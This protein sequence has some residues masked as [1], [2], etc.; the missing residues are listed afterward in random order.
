MTEASEPKPHITTVEA[1]LDALRRCLQAMQQVTVAVSGGV[2][3]MTLATVAHQTL[4][5]KAHMVHAVSAAV[6]AAD[7]ARVAEYA[8]TQQWHFTTVQTGEIDTPNY[9]QNPVNR[10][11]FCKSCLYSTLEQLDVGQVVSGTNTDDLGDYRPGLIAAKEHRIRHPYVEANISKAE[12]RAIAKFLGLSEL[13]ELPASPCLASRVETGTVIQPAQ[14][15]LINRVETWLRAQI[16]GENIRCRLSASHIELQLDA[17]LLS[18]LSAAVQ[19]QLIDRVHAMAKDA[20]WQLPV[21][22]N[23]YQRGSAFIRKVS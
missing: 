23:S 21:T 18:Q 11:Y 3:S 7:S 6:P 15:L 10:C 14:L 2:D 22:I 9:Q 13:S 20:G 5:H 1:K 8:K 17:A 19:Q 12:V 16:G 4:G